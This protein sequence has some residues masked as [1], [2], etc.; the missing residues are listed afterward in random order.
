VATARLQEC[1]DVGLMVRV[2]GSGPAGPSRTAAS[3]FLHSPCSTCSPGLDS[4]PCHLTDLPLLLLVTTSDES[5]YRDISVLHFIPVR[6][7]QTNLDIL[8]AIAPTAHA[9]TGK[10]NPCQ[11]RHYGRQWQSTN[12]QF[13]K[14]LCDQAEDFALLSRAGAR[15]RCERWRD[16]SKY[17]MPPS[18]RSIHFT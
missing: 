1:R 15:Q 18:K 6:Y 3:S 2:G 17:S 7:S 13:S 10:T 11:Q 16:A 9:I 12:Y 14:R 5:N 4:A 8:V